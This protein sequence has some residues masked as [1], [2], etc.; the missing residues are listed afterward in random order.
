M[1]GVIVFRQALGRG[2]GGFNFIH[3]I[4]VG[5]LYNAVGPALQ[6]VFNAVHHARG[7]KR[8][9]GLVALARGLLQLAVNARALVGAVV[10]AGRGAGVYVAAA[11]HKFHQGAHRKLYRFQK[12]RLPAMR[13]PACYL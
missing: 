13:P 11:Q 9:L 3:H 7:L 10:P 5:R 4:P 2:A 12:I 1:Q 6:P 8:H